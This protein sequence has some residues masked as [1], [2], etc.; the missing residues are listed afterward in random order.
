MDISDPKLDLLERDI[1]ARLKPVC[2]EMSPEEFLELVRDIARV[3]LKYGPQSLASEQLHGPTADL[4]R[5]A[6]DSNDQ[7]RVEESLA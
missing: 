5:T 6:N 4:I 1:A 7:D 3:K 2:T